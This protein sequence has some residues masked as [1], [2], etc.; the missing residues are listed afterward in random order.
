M[1]VYIDLAYFREVVGDEA[2][3]D[4]LSHRVR[5]AEID[6]D[7]EDSDAVKA[8]S[9]AILVAEGEADAKLG[10]R[11]TAEQLASLDESGHSEFVKDAVCRIA[12]YK[13]A[14]L[15]LPISDEIK[16]AYDRACSTLKEIGK[17]ELS[18]GRDDPHPPPKHSQT[19]DTVCERGLARLRSW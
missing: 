18:A 11:F 9:R 10:R 5:G 8:I 17:G 15:A 7:D 2:L 13:L 4:V 6:L 19:I 12:L 14:P 16:S 3:Y 1:G